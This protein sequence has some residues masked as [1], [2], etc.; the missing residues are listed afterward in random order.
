MSWQVGGLFAFGLW[1]L[2]LVLY[3]VRLYMRVVHWVY[4]SKYL[5]LYRLFVCFTAFLI[6]RFLMVLV[7]YRCVMYATLCL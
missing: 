3:C 5:L 2:S 4:L 7:V 1:S 6:W